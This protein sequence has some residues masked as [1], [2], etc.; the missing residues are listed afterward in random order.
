MKEIENTLDIYIYIYSAFFHIFC[1]KNERHRKTLG[2]DTSD[3]KA[4]PTALQAAIEWQEGHWNWSAVPFEF[5]AESPT[6]N[7]KASTGTSPICT[8][9]LQIHLAR[10]L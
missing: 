4:L 6:R 5:V 8:R 10:M 2:T 7:F 9:D 3:M 1:F